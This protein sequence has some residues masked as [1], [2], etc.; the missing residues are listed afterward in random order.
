MAKIDIAF[1]EK[2]I[3][4]KNKMLVYPETLKNSKYRKTKKVFRIIMPNNI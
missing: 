3:I 4:G 1:A 2:K